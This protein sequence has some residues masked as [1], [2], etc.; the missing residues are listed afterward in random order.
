M[1][2]RVVKFQTCSLTPLDGQ[3]ELSLRLRQKSLVTTDPGGGSC[4][5]RLRMGLRFRRRRRRATPISAAGR[6]SAAPRPA[7]PLSLKD[8]SRPR[9]HF[10]PL[11]ARLGRFRWILCYH[12]W[13]ECPRHGRA[14][15]LLEQRDLALREFDGGDHAFILQQSQLA[16]PGSQRVTTRRRDSG[17]RKGS[18]TAGSSRCGC[19]SGHSWRRNRFWEARVQRLRR[20]RGHRG[21]AR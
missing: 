1:R 4:Q 6:I 2:C 5:R 19:G 20:H 11:S 10:R 17:R 8:A 12:F 15:G 14:D 3:S 7:L 18:G 9:L 13:S 16:D 21:W